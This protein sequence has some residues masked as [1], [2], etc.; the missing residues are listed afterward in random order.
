MGWRNLK[1]ASKGIKNAVSGVS[2]N[3]LAS[4]GEKS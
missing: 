1:D 4:A 3:T 2:K